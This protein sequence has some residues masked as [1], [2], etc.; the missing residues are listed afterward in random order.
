MGTLAAMEMWVHGRDHKAEWREWERKLTSI[1]N[2][3][4]SIPSV[5]IE[6]KNPELRSNV[7]P[8]LSIS[9]DQKIVKIMPREASEQLYEGE[10]AIEMPFEDAG[11]TIM[12]YMLEPGDEVQ[13]GRRL[14]EVLS[15]TVR[16]KA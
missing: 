5:I 9:W 15:Q 14:H 12:S 10:P 2:R 8:A 11:L 6:M 7:A 4:N 13:V 1:S 3:I 16:E